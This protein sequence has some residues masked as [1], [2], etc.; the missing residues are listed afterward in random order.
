MADEVEQDSVTV[1]TIEA[2]NRFNEAFAL[3]DVDAIM[4]A[5]T[6]DCVFGED[7]RDPDANEQANL[8]GIMGRRG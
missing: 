4:A 7:L 2:V 8:L 1:G 5:M 3:R 6:E